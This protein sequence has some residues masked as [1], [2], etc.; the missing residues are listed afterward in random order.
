M[1]VLEA[2]CGG[3]AVSSRLTL[4]GRI[5]RGILDALRDVWVGRYFAVAGV[6]LSFLGWGMGAALQKRLAFF[7]RRGLFERRLSAFEGL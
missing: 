3:W 7:A 5:A 6:S 4:P 1:S 2:L